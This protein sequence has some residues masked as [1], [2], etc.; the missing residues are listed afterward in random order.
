MK[1]FQENNNYFS[2]P[3]TFF[4]FLYLKVVL[5]IVHND[6]NHRSSLVSKSLPVENSILVTCFFS[7]NKKN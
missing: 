3:I 6:V 5:Y 7:A 1:I 4:I 2:Q